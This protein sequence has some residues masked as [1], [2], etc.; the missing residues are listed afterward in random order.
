MKIDSDI[1]LSDNFFENHKLIKNNFFVGE[2]RCGRNK[3]E[4]CLHGNIYL[5]L[6]DYFKINGY[7]EY[8]K[9]YGWDDSDFTIRLMLCGLTKKLFNYD[10][11]YHVPHEETTRT[12]NLPNNMNSMLMTF[13]NK[14][15][16]ENIIWNNKH[17]M[18]QFKFFIKNKYFIICDRIKGDEYCIDKKTYEESL[19][20][21]TKL[22]KS[23]RFL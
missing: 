1:I 11:L 15:C 3:N 21:N 20:K 23:W 19:E 4:E 5:F 9:D 16:L 18:Q 17:K 22:L 2:Y 7:N 6:N 12:I 8:I 14:T 13:V 10:Y